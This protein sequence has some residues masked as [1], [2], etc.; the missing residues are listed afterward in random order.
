MCCDDLVEGGNAILDGSNSLAVS[1]PKGE[2]EEVVALVE[3]GLDALHGRVVIPGGG[4]VPPLGINDGYRAGHLRRA[5]PD[6]RSE[7]FTPIPFRQ[8]V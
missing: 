6:I 8:T 2:R 7:Q 5:M 3:H 1:R 4:C